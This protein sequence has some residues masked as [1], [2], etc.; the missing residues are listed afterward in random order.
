MSVALNDIYCWLHI[1]MI[2]GGPISI[3]PQTD[4]LS[5]TYWIYLCLSYVNHSKGVRIARWY[6][7]VVVVYTAKISS[8]ND[9]ILFFLLRQTVVL[10][11]TPACDSLLFI[12]LRTGK[13]PKITTE[14]Y[15]ANIW[16]Y[17]WSVVCTR[18]NGVPEA[19][20]RFRGYHQ[21]R[22]PIRSRFFYI[23]KIPARIYIYI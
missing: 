21:S 3:D 12:K 16:I 6:V 5:F 20:D 22:F 23:N 7:V 2:A 19:C 1:Y 15:Y 4:I 18:I 17:V 10:K 11:C 13:F 8:S 14:L 9:W